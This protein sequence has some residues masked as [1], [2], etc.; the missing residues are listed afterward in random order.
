M[1][2]GILPHRAPGM[3]ICGTI[4]DVLTVKVSQCLFLE[5][6]VSRRVTGILASVIQT[7]V[8]SKDTST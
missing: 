3:S 4:P 6:R 8:L 7:K 1:G 2:M 5:I